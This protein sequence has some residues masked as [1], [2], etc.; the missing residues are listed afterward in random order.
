[1]SVLWGVALLIVGM[2]LRLNPML[3]V[4]TSALTT[5]ILA[6]MTPLTLLA[7][8]GDNFRDKRFL[9]LFLLVLPLVATLESLGL[10]EYLKRAMAA[11]RNT[12]LA[13]VLSSYFLV[14]QIAAACGL[15]SLGGHPQS[16]RPLLVP[17]AE[18]AAIQRFGVLKKAQLDKL[19]AFCAGT[20]N[21]A[22]FFG[23]DIFLAFGAVLLI[24]ATLKDYGIEAQALHISLWAIPTAICA[25]LIHL[26][27]I[28]RLRL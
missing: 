6:G 15:T 10:R 24:Q 26:I 5:G 3:V 17:L 2:A 20:D 18:S 28:R 16:V 11:R 23:E 1:M 25:G 19:K 21:V 7:L 22:L 8:I 9:M 4:L 14:R 12:T 27:R 13:S